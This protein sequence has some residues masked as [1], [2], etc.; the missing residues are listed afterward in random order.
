MV[1]MVYDILFFNKIAC[2]QFSISAPISLE[3]S[4][5]GLKN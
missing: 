1:D 5:K 3:L 4:P 2:V